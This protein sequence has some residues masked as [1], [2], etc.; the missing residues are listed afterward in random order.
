MKENQSAETQKC[1]ICIVND[2]IDCGY[3]VKDWWTQEFD[4]THPNA[5]EMECDGCYEIR[6]NECRKIK[7]EE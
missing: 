6:C 4:C 2:A 7:P 3:G 5:D 1:P